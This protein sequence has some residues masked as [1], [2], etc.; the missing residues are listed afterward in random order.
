MHN[1]IHNPERP[2]SVIG[3][4]ARENRRYWVPYCPTFATLEQAEQHARNVWGTDWAAPQ[5]NGITLSVG[6]LTRDIV[7]GN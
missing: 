7:E 5:W 2:Y 4:N 6:I 3:Y 1:D